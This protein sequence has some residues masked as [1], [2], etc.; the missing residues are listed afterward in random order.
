MPFAIASG[1]RRAV[2]MPVAF[3]DTCAEDRREEEQ[4]RRTT[5]RVEKLMLNVFGSVNV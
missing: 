3:P 2:S 1:C 4:R 5:L